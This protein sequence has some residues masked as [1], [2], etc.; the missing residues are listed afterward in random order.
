MAHQVHDRLSGRQSWIRELIFWQFFR[1]GSP[2][3]YLLTLADQTQ[4][5]S[6]TTTAA[7]KRR[8][9]AKGYERT[10][11]VNVYGEK[12]PSFFKKKK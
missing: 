1:C 4:K 6:L 12:H 7:E 11:C 10:M 2:P 8:I 9:T 5:H 3:Y